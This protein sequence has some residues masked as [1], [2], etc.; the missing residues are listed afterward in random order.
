MRRHIFNAVFYSL[1]FGILFF[2][3]YRLAFMV[4]PSRGLPGYRQYQ[5]GVMAISAGVGLMV[6]VPNLIIEYLIGGWASRL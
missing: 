5:L 1:C 2:A 3:M 4:P 6:V